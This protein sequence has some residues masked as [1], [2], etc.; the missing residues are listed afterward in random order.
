[1]FIRLMKILKTSTDWVFLFKE[2]S[3]AD[4]L[5]LSMQ[6]KSNERMLWDKYLMLKIVLGLNG[7]EQV[8][9]L[10]QTK[11]WY[12][13][14]DSYELYQIFFSVDEKIVKRMKFY[15]IFR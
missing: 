12:K 8:C 1:M 6:I 13:K 10:Q 14:R 5:S 9:K 7:K 2:G 15:Y 4:L 11:F 3:I